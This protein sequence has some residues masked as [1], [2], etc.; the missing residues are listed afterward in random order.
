MLVTLKTPKTPRKR[1]SSLR[2]PG[3]YAGVSRMLYR[4]GVGAEAHAAHMMPI[5]PSEAQDV[6]KRFC[7]LTKVTFAGVRG[8]AARSG[9]HVTMPRAA[10]GETRHDGAPLLRLGIALHECAHVIAYAQA[11]R[12]G[13]TIQPHGRAFCETFAQLLREF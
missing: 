3:E 8:R 2:I 13:R 4:L 1:R 6:I 5:T 11:R 9:A 12:A 10:Q 7:P